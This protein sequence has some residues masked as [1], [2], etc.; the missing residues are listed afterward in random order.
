[1]INRKLTDEQELDLANDYKA[2]IPLKDIIKKFDISMKCIANALRR[3]GV[4]RINQERRRYKVN[5]DYFESIDSED[6]AYFLGLLY[7]DGCNHGVSIS[8]SLQKCD[9]DILDKFKQN[10][11]FEGNIY[12]YQHE[13]KHKEYWKLNIKNVKNYCLIRISSKK[14]SEDLLKHGCG[15]RK[16]LTLE[17]PETIPD[18]LMVHFIRGYIDGDGWVVLDLTNN[19]G[20]IG[21][22]GT[23]GFCNKVKEYIE[24][25]LEIN[26]NIK[27][28]QTYEIMYRIDIQGNNQFLKMTKWL[29]KDATIYL[30]R[31]YNKYLEC[32]KIILEK[33]SNYREKLK[34]E[35]KGSKN[36]RSFLTEEIVKSIRHDYLNNMR[37]IHIEQ[38]YGLSHVH[39]QKIIHNK[40]W[41]NI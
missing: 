29:Y 26:V 2:N 22:I 12:E 13:R 6:K 37:P 20:L 3:Q 35:R 27:Q 8:I 14:I 21:L 40:I 4:Q 24:K 34:T 16:S 32:K 19:N 1:M 18:H 33:Q 15:P 36:G 17:F 30:D 5:D 10:I 39:V 7:A 31:K 25:K 11:S 41:Q 38:K 23:F 9:K 28:A